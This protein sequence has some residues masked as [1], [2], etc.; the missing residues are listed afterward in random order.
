MEWKEK[1]S[2]KVKKIDDQHKKLFKL[3]NC[4]HDAEAECKGRK[5]S[6]DAINAMLEYA[7]VHFSTE[8]GYFEKFIFPGAKA[9]IK[10]HEAFTKKAIRLY[11][12]FKGTK[13]DV[14]KEMLDYL[15]EWW[16][17][18]V[19]KVDRGYM[20]CFSDNALKR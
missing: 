15:K 3:I 14:S 18:H 9:H 2:V 13:G 17:N 1:Y 4:F 12:N 19:T 5:G 10:E 11:D 16:T 6:M 20:K 7:R 8:E